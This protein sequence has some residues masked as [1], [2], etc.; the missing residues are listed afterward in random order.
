MI[1]T[2][3]FRAAVIVALSADISGAQVISQSVSDTPGPAVGA[4]VPEFQLSDQTGVKSQPPKHHG[5]ERP[6]ARVLSLRRLVTLLQRTARGAATESAGDPQ[7]GACSR[8][9]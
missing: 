4:K 8:S 9:H 5:S 2:G 3:L 6:D 7:A 1:V